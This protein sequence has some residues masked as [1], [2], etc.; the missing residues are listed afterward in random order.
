MKKQFYFVE[1]IVWYGGI[2][3][4]FHF[5]STLLQLASKLKFSKNFLYLKKSDNLALFNIN[6][7]GFS[8]ANELEIS[9][10][11]QVQELSHKI[12]CYCKKL[13]LM[14]LCNS[15]MHPQ[16]MNFTPGKVLYDLNKKV[17]IPRNCVLLYIFIQCKNCSQ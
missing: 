14:Q 2:T 4:C 11:R 8:Y 3:L 15:K 17:I 5:P 10:W 16:S 13:T 12:Y 9:V 6:V 1:K 7:S